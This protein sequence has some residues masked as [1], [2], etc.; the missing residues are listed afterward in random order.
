VAAVASR[1]Y[2]GRRKEYHRRREEG[3]PSASP[4]GR[5]ES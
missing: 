2:P 4:A 3:S 5:C 1:V